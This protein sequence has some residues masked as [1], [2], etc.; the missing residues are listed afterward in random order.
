M[1][2]LEDDMFVPLVDINACEYITV[3]SLIVSTTIAALLFHLF[4]PRALVRLR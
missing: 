1:Y 3:D 4:I 2:Q